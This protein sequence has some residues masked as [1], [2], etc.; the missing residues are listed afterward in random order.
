MAF[1]NVLT[2]LRASVLRPRFHAPAREMSIFQ[3]FKEK[4]SEKLEE[5]KN[6]KQTQAYMDQVKYLATTPTYTLQDHYDQMKKQAADGGVS[7]WKS[8]MPGVSSMPQIQQMKN[9]LTIME[10]FEP[11]VRNDPKLINGKVKRIVSEKCGQPV[12]EINNMMRSYE[13]LDALRS[14]LRKRVERNL[15]L[16]ST[17]EDT[18][19]MIREDP[20]GFPT[21]GMRPKAA[22]GSMP[23][24][25]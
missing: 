8:M 21:R 5:R 23:R 4:V 19:E 16:P 18:T 1:R 7:G 14:W 10:A 3:G 25:R 17:L 20:T 2:G 24:R 11:N 22:R 13:Q 9:F 15:P 6:E 12:E